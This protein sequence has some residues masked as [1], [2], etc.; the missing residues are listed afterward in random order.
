M[1]SENI[2][3]DTKQLDR[4]SIQFKSLGNEMPAA[5]ASA[6][7]RTLDFV[8]TRIG[9]IVPQEY[10]IKTGEVKE[11]M[12]K[13]KASKTSLDAS[14]TSKGHTLSFAHFPHSPETPVIA[15]TLGASHEKAR[16][17]VK[18]KKSKGR[19][20][21]KTGFIAKTGAK[22][23]D[24]IP[25]NVFHRLT[26]NRLPIAPIRTLSVPQMIGNEKM[27]PEI[28]EAAQ[29][30]LAERIEHEIDW[31]LNNVKKQIKG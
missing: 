11:T 5:A 6:L 26:K 9:R 25:Y 21:S 3:V 1:S 13:R 31:R 23:V 10:A 15:L 24:K 2:F 29:K 14:I 19:V 27:E 8:V 16:V 18:I 12:S 22:S 4:L 30:K 17:K 28:Q 20:T 7:N